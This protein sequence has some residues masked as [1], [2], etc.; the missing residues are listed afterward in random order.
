MRICWDNLGGTILTKNGKF[1]KGSNTYIY[2]E[3]CGFCQNSYLTTARSIKL[4]NG[5]QCSISCRLKLS[6]P[7]KN[8]SVREKI[9]KSRAGQD[10]WN[11]GK[12]GVYSKETLKKMSE[13]SKGKT[14]DKNPNWRHGLSYTTSYYCAHSARRRAQK[15]VGK[16][17]LTL[18]EK[19]KIKTYYLLRETFGDEWEVDH[20]IPLS[21]GGRHHPK[22]LQII[23]KSENRKKYNR[24]QGKK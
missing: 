7:S 3:S 8:K 14:G 9:S 19:L 21:K 18:T 12:V 4:G 15:R 13:S 10:P 22:N 11:K 1:L 2:V 16:E 5:K 23:P 24:I 20:I 17:K 6:N